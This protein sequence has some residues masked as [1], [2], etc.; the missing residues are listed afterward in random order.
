M[1][2]QSQ[3]PC[4]KHKRYRLFLRLLFFVLSVV[5]TAWAA[6][7][8]YYSNLPGSLVRSV[9]AVAS[10]IIALSIAF[11]A[12]SFKCGIITYGIAFGVVFIW[13][14][15][16]PASN[17]RHWQQDVA[18]LPYADISGNTITI[19]NIRNFDYTSSTDYTPA[20][21][22]KTVYLDQLQTV[23]FFLIYWG[24]KLMAHTI[25]SF[26]FE[27]GTYIAISIETRKEKGEEYS[28][29]KGFFKKFELTYVVADERDVVRLRSNYREE[30]VYLYRLKV[31]TQLARDV[32]LD[33]FKV[34]N[35][36]VEQPKWY[37]ALTHNCTTTIRGHT[38]PYN[39][40]AKF[41]WRMLANGLIDEMGYER[42][43]IA[44]HLP[45][46]QLKKQSLINPHA[47][48]LDQDPDFSHKIR[49]ELPL[50]KQ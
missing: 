9:C 47:Q 16:I 5:P 22:D 20:Y 15:L 1:D 28:A 42:G 44:T 23:D 8:I 14:W 36:L 46:E 12:P 33:Y 45:F 3:T 49:K 13:W 7:A 41:D 29:I 50:G 4:Q 35:R 10:F 19:H 31:E 27:D 37:N 11:R 43:A 17:H 32:F 6:M 39:P 38:K 34:I 24:P 48:T 25:M 30:D 18:V 2:D 26:G 40:E 21:Y